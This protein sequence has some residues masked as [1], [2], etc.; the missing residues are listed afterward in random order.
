MEKNTTVVKPVGF[1]IVGFQSLQHV[2]YYFIFLAF[3]Y[4]GTL[5]ANF[6]LMSVIWLSHSLHT[7]KY[8]AV[9]NLSI[10]DVLISTVLI[11][12]CIDYFLLDSRFVLYDSCLTQ[13][14]FFHY[15]YCVESL[16]LV[17][18]AYERFVSICFPLRCSTINTNSRMFYIIVTC[19]V[20]TLGF[21]IV[22]IVFIT[23]LSFCKPSPLVASYFCDHGPLY[24][25]A[26]SDS[27]A[28]WKIG[29]TYTVGFIFMPLAVIALSYVCIIAAL[30]KIASAE[31]RWKAFK[32]CTAHIILVVMFYIPVLVI[33]MIAGL[34]TG[35]DAD[36][37][38]LNTSLS[39]S[40]PP[41][42]NPIIYTLKTEE[43]MEQIKL[44][45]RKQKVKLLK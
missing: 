6:L 13:M 28:N 30:L 8:L 32:T 20:F 4:L 19:W 25:T 42:L 1:L 3:V 35:I 21:L 7:P 44:F 14:F 2:N 34:G 40:L 16:I 36:T 33:Y 45:L 29:Y 5:I 38:I 12:K 10:V 43:V 26:C 39:A 37:R 23:K 18:M 24:R 17:V 41:L 15:F 27:S 9:F 11:P 22:L 31:G